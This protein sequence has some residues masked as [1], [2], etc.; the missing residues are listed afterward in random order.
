[1]TR[2]QVFWSKVRELQ[3]EI[4]RDHG[5]FS[6]ITSLPD[7]IPGGRAGVV[8]EA[9]SQVAAEA[10][11]RGTHRLATAEEV[12]EHQRDQERRALEI[13]RREASRGENGERRI[14]ISLPPK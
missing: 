11:T 4:E 1:M 5:R 13:R 9:T 14:F 12:A 8:C 6:C 10:I 2:L 7:A 3:S